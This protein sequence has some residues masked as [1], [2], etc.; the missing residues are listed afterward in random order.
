MAAVLAPSAGLGAPASTSPST[1]L[2]SSRTHATPRGTMAAYLDWMGGWGKAAK[3]I[4]DLFIEPD[5]GLQ[6]EHRFPPRRQSSVR[7]SGTA[8][9]SAS[10]SGPGQAGVY[11]VPAVCEL[12]A[13]EMCLKDFV[14]R[15]A[16]I[17][18][19]LGTPGLRRLGLPTTSPQSHEPLSG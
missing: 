3:E 16:S 4:M 1:L 17:A 18:R 19:P 5:V 14:S 6:I 8:A 11:T 7:Q 13:R 10:L 12:V 2:A 9:A 15:R